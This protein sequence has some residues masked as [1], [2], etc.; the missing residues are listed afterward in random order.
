MNENALHPGRIG[1]REGMVAPGA[2][3]AGECIARDVVTAR[4]RDLANGS[5]HVVDRDFEKTFGNR[6][7][8]L[9]ADG[10]GYLLK[11]SARRLGVERKIAVRTK[12]RRELRWI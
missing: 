9:V 2:A 12:H 7:Q 1:D 8:G 6:L 5:R 10:L 11:S 3:E 4:D